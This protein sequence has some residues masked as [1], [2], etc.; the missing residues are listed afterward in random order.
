MLNQAH[1]STELL[2]FTLF[3]LL[4]TAATLGFGGVGAMF[5]PMFLSGG[6]LGTAFAQS[7][8]HTPVVGMYAAV[9]MACFIAA[10]YKTPLASVVFVAEATGGHGF[11]IPALIGAAVAYTISGDASISADQQIREARAEA[12]SEARNAQEAST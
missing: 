3:K 11:I 12:Q 4:A 5:V 10:A 1:S 2:V 9:G 8:V 6:C 7:V